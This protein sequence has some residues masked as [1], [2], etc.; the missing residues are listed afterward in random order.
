MSPDRLN[1][2]NDSNHSQSNYN[3]NYN[4]NSYNYNSNYSYTTNNNQ[5]S[6][7]NNQ[8]YTTNNTTGGLGANTASTSDSN[9]K[10]QLKVHQEHNQLL[11]LKH[12]RKTNSRITILGVNVHIMYMIKLVVQ[13]V[14]L[15]VM[16]ITGQQRNL[17]IL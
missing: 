17:V 13:S 10:L 15:G 14:T 6:T 1:H 8:S 4:N 9:V 3:H 7:N 12:F 16:Q 2:T 11:R 5:T